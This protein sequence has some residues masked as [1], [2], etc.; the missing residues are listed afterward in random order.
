VLAR[1][2]ESPESGSPLAQRGT[3]DAIMYG[4]WDIPLRSADELAAEVAAAGFTEVS[5]HRSDFATTLLA[6][7]GDG[8]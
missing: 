1:A 2:S 5:V 8:G 3:L 4:Q 6:S 7:R